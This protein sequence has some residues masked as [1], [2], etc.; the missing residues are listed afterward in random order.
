MYVAR[1]KPGGEELT[2]RLRGRPSPPEI[3]TGSS[4]PVASW[5]GGAI[6]GFFAS[7]RAAFCTWLARYLGPLLTAVGHRQ[8]R[9]SD[10]AT[11]QREL[12]GPVS[13]KYPQERLYAAQLTT[14][15][16][17]KGSGIPAHR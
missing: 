9:A 12:L 7:W 6:P 8:G 3:A 13:F 2:W 17:P 14:L 4:H 10:P 1:A 15:P 16:S 11:L 5:H